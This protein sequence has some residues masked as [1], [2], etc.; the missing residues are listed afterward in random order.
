MVS[1][2]ICKPEIDLNS[3]RKCQTSQSIEKIIHKKTKFTKS[4]LK[5]SIDKVI[6]KI[7]PKIQNKTKLI[8]IQN[9]K[10]KSKETSILVK[11]EIKKTETTG[12]SKMNNN[13]MKMSINEFK[14]LELVGIIIF[15]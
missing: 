12:T 15:N 8:E 5:I 3:Q 14:H 10:P 9:L 2:S 11:K 6:N 7:Q 1:S 13:H 4:S